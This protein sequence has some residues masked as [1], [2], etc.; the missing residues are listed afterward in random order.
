MTPAAFRSVF[1]EFDR[2]DI[3][4]LSDRALCAYTRIAASVCEA[5]RTVGSERMFGAGDACRTMVRSL[6]REL[7]LRYAR[8]R[9]MARRAALLSGMY[10]LRDA[11]VLSDDRS[12]A[13]LDRRA[14]RLIADCMAHPAAQ[15]DPETLYPILHLV[16]A[17][18]CG[19]TADDPQIEFLHGHL[20]RWAATLDGS[21]R[22]PDVSD[23]E[24]LGRIA[25]LDRC[26]YLLLDDRY[27]ATAVAAY[28]SYCVGRRLCPA[29][30][31]LTSDR[32]REV[33]LEYD[34]ILGGTL[35][36]RGDEA[37]AARLAARLERHIATLPAT[38]DDALLCRSVVVADFCRTR[39]AS[40]EDTVL[41]AV[42]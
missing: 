42:P 9:C 36:G 12:E 28:A 21:G 41:C 6:R 29:A 2:S 13:L 35:A 25:L 11:A 30:G 7:S 16:A 1:T 14:E 4:R 24:A 32:L 23:A 17:C 39:V 20:S 8:R 40:I 34:L 31:P 19:P 22:W 5:V 10:A 33:V 26:T 15:A 37:H 18:A 38:D 3:T 27:R